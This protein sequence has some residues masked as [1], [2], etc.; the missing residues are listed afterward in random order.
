MKRSNRWLWLVAGLAIVGV[1]IALA[2]APLR[3]PLLSGSTYNRA[4]DGY[5]AWYAYMQEREVPIQRWQK[6][7]GT[8]WSSAPE[9]RPRV[10][11][12]VFPA[13]Q[14]ER[15]LFSASWSDWVAAGNT[16]IELG[17]EQPVTGANFSTLQ[18]SEEDY[19]V[20]IETRRRRLL[21]SGSTGRERL[22]D[23]YGASV[24]ETPVGSGRI[25]RATTP[26]LAAN[27]YQNE[28]GNFAFLEHLV[29]ES[30]GEIWVDEYLHGYRDKESA[31]SAAADG[32][33]GWP[34]YLARTPWLPIAVQAVAICAIAWASH[35]RL[36]AAVVLQE[37]E[38]N[39][40]EAYINALASVLRQARSAEFVV[41]TVSKAERESLQRS[42][43]LGSLAVDDATLIQ[44]WTNQTKRPASDLE[45]LF[46]NRDWPHSE[47]DLAAWLAKIRGLRPDRRP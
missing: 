35:R 39:N 4:P 11:L 22:G 29:R 20:R 21:A 24:W 42:L 9:N 25:I 47:K 37:P 7:P 18:R 3:S 40:S 8:L 34:A 46:D 15:A 38:Q 31:Q 45:P 36:G 12:R 28:P 5:G 43:G 1:S 27:A 41:E 6:S 19:R 32:P 10:L 13:G 2:A 17:V 44:A 30:G 33:N 16:L 23:R 14:E 26:F